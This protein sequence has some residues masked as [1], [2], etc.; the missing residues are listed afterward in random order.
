MKNNFGYIIIGS[1]IA[2]L[3]TA[4]TL[5]DSGSIAIF[6]K[7]NPA[8]SSTNLAQGGMAAIVG[9]GDQADWHIEDTLKAGDFHNKKKAVDLLV[10]NSREAL[11]W[12]KIR[13]YCL[14]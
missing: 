5:K 6:T 3:T 9:E 11:L 2:G 14:I 4:L 12:L 1:G 10:K 13:V 7:K 8:D